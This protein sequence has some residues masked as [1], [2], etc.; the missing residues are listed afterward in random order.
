MSKVFIS[1]RR[2]DSKDVVG[3]IYDYLLDEFGE[4]NLFKDVDSI[5]LGDDFR[6]VIENSVQSCDVIIAVIGSKWLDITD[7]S[8]NR[9]IDD[10]NDFVH[11]EIEAGLKRNIPVIP[12][13]VTNASMPTQ[14]QLPEAL[15]KL[16]FQNG[17]QIRADP[18]FKNDVKR[19]I[20]SLH[21]KVKFR[22]KYFSIKNIVITT[23]L[24]STIF[25]VIFYNLT[26][27]P[28]KGIKKTPVFI[29]AL[30]GIYAGLD[31]NNHNKL[32][33]KWDTKQL[34]L[35][36]RNCQFLGEI[37]QKDNYWSI[38]AKGQD[39]MC[40]LVDSPFIDKEVG[41]VT[42]IKGSLANSGKVMAAL[43][44][45]NI[46]SLSGFSGIYK[47]KY[48]DLEDERDH[49]K[50]EQEIV[51]Q[52]LLK[53]EKARQ[54]LLKTEQEKIIQMQYLKSRINVEKI[55]GKWVFSF[56]GGDVDTFVKLS[57]EPFFFDHN[58][59]SKDKLR[60]KYLELYNKKSNEWDKSEVL[61]IKVQTA[62]E[63]KDEGY[64]LSKDRIFNSLNLTLEDFTISITVKYKNRK[65]GI[66]LVA[67]KFGDDFEIVGMWD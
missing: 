39:G 11:I 10:P 22:K 24:F 59:L 32:T 14:A 43:V 62:K 49:I 38:I 13:L 55:A 12:V 54:D 9:R 51:G 47:F 40:D 46:G 56:M 36:I 8:G 61:A 19:L 67:R 27:S 28:L 5:P 18:D 63:L 53:K 1:Y 58:L 41:R 45:F 17:M 21:I 50:E 48:H 26:S 57:S 4:V 15:K 52:D 66:L 60:I 35:L 16:S 30:D 2:D 6:K 64:D 3:R 25:L 34:D 37:Y 20:K 29:G 44:N 23:I 31:K 65:E 7:A 33:V 42:P